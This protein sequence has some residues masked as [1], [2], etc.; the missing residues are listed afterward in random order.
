MWDEAQGEKM[1]APQRVKEGGIW[2]ELELEQ[3]LTLPN[4]FRRN[5]VRRNTSHVVAPRKLSDFI[6]SEFQVAQ[7][8]P[9][10]PSDFLPSPRNEPERW[11]QDPVFFLCTEG[12]PE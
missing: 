11:T 6:F 1:A 3:M 8:S 5:F 7:V 2:T 10:P 12:R 9:L 4:I